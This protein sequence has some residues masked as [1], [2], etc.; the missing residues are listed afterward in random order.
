[1]ERMEQERAEMNAE[2]EA[3]IER[4]L[5][6]MAVDVDDSD[7]GSRPTSRMSSRSAPSTLRRSGSRARPMRSFSTESTL[8]ESFPPSGFREE[9]EVRAKH[10][11]STVPE[12]DE[13]EEED[14]TISPTKRK[15][16]SATQADLLQDGMAAVDEG[17]NSTSDIV[18]QKML[19]I[20]RKVS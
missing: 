3:Q 18:T 11:A 12:M 20:Q 17:I 5:E 7:Y 10:R 2:V 8:T 19:R 9:D 13:P 16:F 1:M 15:R 6:S 14:D 4:A